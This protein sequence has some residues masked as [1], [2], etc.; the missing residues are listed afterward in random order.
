MDERALSRF[1][2]A[3]GIATAGLTL[4]A[5]GVFG[6]LSPPTGSD[7]PVEVAKFFANHQMAVYVAAY[8]AALSIGT[9]LMFY[10]GLRDVLRRRAPGSETL[11]T[12]GLVGGIAFISILF[13]AFAIL[14]QLAYRKGAGDPGLQQS[15]FDVQA[16]ITS[17]P[18]A[19]SV[20]A[21]SVVVLR[22]RVFAPWVGWYG[23]AVAAIHL[24]SVGSLA[25]EGFFTPGVVAGLVAPLMF[26]VWL[27]A[28]SVELL[29]RP[30]FA[31]RTT[32]GQP[33]PAAF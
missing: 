32:L 3:S 14:L 1:T 7:S 17:V 24:I 31:S 12:T 18:T 10:V 8:I 20:I 23:F 15:L 30:T 4:V 13:V 26:E 33:K 6:A 28:V 27:V 16:L 5:L 25:H 22:E 29:M 19:V 11:A 2:A 9:N 21:I